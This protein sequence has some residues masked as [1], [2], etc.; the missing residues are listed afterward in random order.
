MRSLAVLAAAWGLVAWPAAG[1]QTFTLD[2]EAGFVLVEPP[3][4][5]S[6]EGRLQAAR[7]ALAEGRLKD[8]LQIVDAF[9]ENNPNNPFVIDARLVR[10]DIRVAQGNYYRALFDYEYVARTSP[11]SEA[12]LIALER[13]FEIARAFVNGAKRRFLGLRILTAKGEAEELLIRIQERVPGSELG[14]K[15]SITL[16]DYFFA[17]GD[18]FQASEAYD[19]FLLNYPDS[20]QREW[21]MLRLIQANL[22]RFRGPEYDATGLIEAK[23]RLDQYRAEFPAS[24]ERI[25]VDALDIRIADAAADKDLNDARWYERRGKPVSAA[26]LYRRVVEDHPQ[27]TAAQVAIARLAGLP[28]PVVEKTALIPL[29][30]TD[31]P[32]R[33]EGEQAIGQL[34]RQGPD[35]RAQR[36]AREEFIQRLRNLESRPDGPGPVDPTTPPEVY[37]R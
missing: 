18:M 34:R 11:A 15:A 6:P 14:E 23:Q 7:T 3:D 31:E 29:S 2:D 32:V 10:G 24:A 16:A 8:A 28:V 13:E 30:A 22:A 20:P 27:S 25:G 21:A 36:Q 37:P 9:I 17:D 35:D 26:Y 19:L 5:S 12:W 4:P 33:R 1:Q